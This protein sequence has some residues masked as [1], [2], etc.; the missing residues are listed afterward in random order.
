[1]YTNITDRARD[2]NNQP[3]QTDTLLC[4]EFQAAAWFRFVNGLMPTSCQQPFR[5]GTQAPIWLKGS[6][7]Q[8]SEGVVDRIACANTQ[9]DDVGPNACCATQIPIQ[10]R[11]CGGFVVYYLRRPPAC[12][13]AYCTGKNETPK[14]PTNKKTTK[15]NKKNNNNHIPIVYV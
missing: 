1:M 15:N 7:P 2:I 13:M 8:V 4:D 5:C 12:P 14:P 10:I 11:N 6:V 3:R 9:P